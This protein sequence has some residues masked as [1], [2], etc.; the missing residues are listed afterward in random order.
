MMLIGNL[1]KITSTDQKEGVINAILEIDKYNS[2]FKGH[3]PGQP[4][5]PGAVMLQMIKEVLERSLNY[6]IRLKKADQIKFL[7]LIDPQ[8]DNVL[9]LSLSYSHDDKDLLRVTASIVFKNNTSLKFK[10]TFIK[11]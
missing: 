7:G 4:V 2:I 8:I 3:F 6:Q 1:Y 11:L 10:G 9:Q 5:L